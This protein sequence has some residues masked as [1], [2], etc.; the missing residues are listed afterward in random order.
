[1]FVGAEVPEAR[2]DLPQRDPEAFFGQVFLLEDWGAEAEKP[3]LFKNIMVLGLAA[4][5]GKA[6]TSRFS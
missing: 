4:F 5:G 6:N 3:H 2:H 1:M